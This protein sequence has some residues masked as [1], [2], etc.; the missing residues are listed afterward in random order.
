MEKT[1]LWF[2]FPYHTLWEIENTK[3]LEIPKKGNIVRGVSVCVGGWVGRGMSP[4]FSI[5]YF[6]LSRKARLSKN[7]HIK[8]VQLPNPKLKHKDKEQCH[9]AGWG[10]TTTGGNHATDLQVVDVPMINLK[11]CNR[12][13][14][15]ILPATVIC[16][17]GYGTD[18][19]FCQVCL[20]SI[21]RIHWKWLKLLNKWIK[22]WINNLSFSLFTGWFWWPSGVQRQSGCWSCF[23]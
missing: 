14:H 7:Q 2:C 6:Q 12:L 19:G 10:S 17:G 8:P 15:N 22:Q 23:L 16:A 13:W 18:K 5:V 20:L 3:A 4:V 1:C 11:E 9:V 21:H